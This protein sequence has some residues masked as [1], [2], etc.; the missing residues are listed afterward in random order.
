MISTSVNPLWR[1]AF[2]FITEP[3]VWYGVNEA[4]GGL[5]LVQFVHELPA[6]HRA[7]NLARVY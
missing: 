4:A 6:A 2:L 5:L 7:I 1:D 3:F